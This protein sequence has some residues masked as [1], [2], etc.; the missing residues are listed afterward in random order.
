ML[1]VLENAAPLTMDEVSRLIL[2]G[3]CSNRWFDKHQ[4]IVCSNGKAGLNFEVTNCSTPNVKLTIDVQHSVGD[5]S[6]TLRL[7]DEMYKWRFVQ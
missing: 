5:G 2:H 1:V 3:P 6:T 4:L 7:A